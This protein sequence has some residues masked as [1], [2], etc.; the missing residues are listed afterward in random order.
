M[1]YIPPPAVPAELPENMQLTSEG[2]EPWLYIPP[3]ALGSATTSENELPEK[4]QLVI[5][6]EELILAKPPPN[7]AAI[8]VLNI[9]LLTVGEPEILSIPPPHWPPAPQ[10][11]V[12][13]ALPPVMVKPSSTAVLSV[14][15]PVVIWNA[16][17]AIVPSLS[18]SPLRMAIFVLQLRSA[19]VVSVPAK[20][21]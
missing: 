9:Q 8:L 13:I 18:I 5:I 20:P 6:G 11:P 16:L 19:S 2:K 4:I 12:Q 3:P 10:V 7:C 21:P 1:L 17:F 15:E 14:P